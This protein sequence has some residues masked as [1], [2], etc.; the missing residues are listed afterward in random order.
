MPRICVRCWAGSRSSMAMTDPSASDTVDSV[1]PPQPDRR[2]HPLSPL[3]VLL[4]HLR[5]FILPIIV[6]LVLGRGDRDELWSL[7]V[8]LLLGVASVW[9]YYTYQYRILEDRLVVRSGLFE[10]QLRQI[11]FSRIHNVAVH[12]SLLHRLF[13]VAEVRLESAAGRKPEA[14]MQVLPLDAAL[15]LEALV[16]SHGAQHDATALADTPDAHLWLRLPLSEVVRLGLIS[17][18]GMVVVGA[19]L[20]ALS[21]MRIQVPDATLKRWARLANAQAHD[22]P[23]TWLQV[24]G[25][26]ILAVLLALA[27]VR[28]LSVALAIL[29]YYDFR[30]TVHGRRLS[31]ERGLMS[32]ARAS[33]PRRRIQTWQLRET[34]LHR[35]FRRRTLQ[36]ETAAST[37]NENQ[38]SV[39]DI[40]P[41]AT[42][43]RCDALIAR[44][45]PAGH[46]PPSQ[47][48]P[49][50]RRAWMPLALPSL[51]LLFP[52][53][54]LVWR[55][56]T[57]GW[58]ALLAVPVFVAMA[59]LH[60]RHA[61]YSVQ[62]ELVAIRS[63]WLSRRWRFAELDKL[64]VIRLSQSPLQRRLG[65]ASLLLDT[66]G[67][68]SIGPPLGIVHVPTSEAE[69]LQRFLQRQVARR[70]LHW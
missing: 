45:L 59:M 31:T 58:L 35:L 56:G 44:L 36:V 25:L 63:G 70:P 57:P 38:R 15:A 48:H 13:K 55:F 65:M 47:W 41:V 33:V 8:I 5:Q 22:H 21:Q 19:T 9:R 18:R 12:Q 23:L 20:V 7:V 17:N 1:L 50:H 43:D 34:P 14:Q 26:V 30:L 46:W 28:L 16:R 61:G 66:A 3:F 64:Q 67:A 29:Q 40:A 27:L 54:V 24:A 69:R 49:L 32:R 42:P 51:L 37:A 52:A 6:F 2:L 68:D 4:H 60:A 53:G 11:P 10:Q 39:R 62:G